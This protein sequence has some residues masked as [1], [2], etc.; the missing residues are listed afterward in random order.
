MDKCIIK[1]SEKPSG[2]SHIRIRP[3]TYRKLTALVCKAN[4]SIT[5]VASELLEF[6]LERTE[7]EYTLREGVDSETADD[8]DN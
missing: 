2:C 7:L 3:E 1:C 5:Y 6:A 4:R 8:S